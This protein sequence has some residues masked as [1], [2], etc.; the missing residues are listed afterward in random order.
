MIKRASL[1]AVLALV[2]APLLLAHGNSRAEVKAEI[3]GKT[4][5]IEYGRP[6]LK[7]RDM[8]GQAQVGMTWRLGADA[9]TTLRNEGAIGLG[10]QTVPAGE[11]VLKAKKVADG[12]WRLLVT[13]GE[14]V[15]AEAPLTT[16]DLSESVELFTIELS[17]AGRFEARWGTRSLA[18][19]ITAR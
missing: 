16:T 11:Y 8:L 17:A 4:V 19:D 18:T 9:A 10:E 3:G 1:A 12:E 14:E 2:A 15:V 6:S 5:T 7:G 13:A